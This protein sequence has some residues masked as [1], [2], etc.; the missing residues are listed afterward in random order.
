M[1]NARRVRNLTAVMVGTASLLLHGVVVNSAPA[2]QPGVSSVERDR[3]IQLYKAGDVKGAIDALRLAARQ[4]ETDVTAWHYLGLALEQKGEHSEAKKAYEKAS[5]LGETI[6][7]QQLE[8]T[9]KGKDIPRAML[10]IRAQ[11]FEAAESAERYVALDP[12]MS[13]SRQED[14][15]VRIESLR[16]FAN[17]A[18]DENLTFYS[19]SEVTT[20]VKVLAKPNPQYT[21]EARRNLISGTVI[22]RCIFGA[23]GRVFGFH[24][25]A[26]LPDGLTERAIEV[27][28]QIKFIPATKDGHPVSMWM[29]VEYNFNVY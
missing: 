27:A 23:N 7:N 9:P 6:L 2:Q 21:Q 11:L 14:W 24:V 5:R 3:G 8:R 19:G 13:K 4:N 29:E 17:L 10:A 12:K 26:G 28:R 1:I 16:G 15:N 22:L 20:R 18:A 25:V